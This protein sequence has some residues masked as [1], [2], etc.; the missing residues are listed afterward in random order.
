TASALALTI[1][2]VAALHDTRAFRR[3]QAML[4]PL[5]ATPHAG[6]AIGLAFL[7]APS[8]WIARALAPLAGWERP[9]DWSLPQ[10]RWGLGF[11][12]GLV[13]KEVPYLLL[14]IMA[15]LNQIPW[16]AQATVAR[17]L[18]Y[19]ASTAWLKVVAPQVLPQ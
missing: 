7:I 12:A 6:I 14:M 1:A 19:R 16:R 18:G 8:G 17:T 5:L 9:P 15:A 13:V 11:V 10:D 3:L 2:I 4:A